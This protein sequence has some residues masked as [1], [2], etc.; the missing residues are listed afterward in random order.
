MT[1][2]GRDSS[3]F[4]HICINCMEEKGEEFVCRYCDYDERTFRLSPSHLRPRMVLQEKYVAGRVLGQGGFG[5]TYIG[6]DTD[7][8]RKVAIKEYFPSQVAH[9]DHNH[10]TIVPSTGKGSASFNKGLEIFIREAR[11]LANFTKTLN[12]VNVY[13]YFS[14]NN[15]AY[16]VMEFLDGHN[17]SKF[18]KSRGGK[19]PLEKSIKILMPVLDTLKAMHAKQFYHRDI[20]PQNIMMTP[21]RGPILIDFGAARQ[22]TGEESQLSDMILKP[23]YSAFESYASKGKIGP[24]TDIY[25]CG[26][27]LYMMITGMPPPPAPDRIHKDDLQ[28]PS[29]IIGDVKEEISKRKLDNVILHALAVK[30]NDRF[31]TVSEFENALKKIVPNGKPH[32]PQRRRVSLALMLVIIVFILVISYGLFPEFRT[33]FSFSNPTP[34]PTSTAAPPTVTPV[35]FSVRDKVRLKEGITWLEGVNPGDIGIVEQID[36]DLLIIR[37]RNGNSEIVSTKDVEKIP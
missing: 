22:I 15:T 17:L 4:L 28:L 10:L 31:K 20:S 3:D 24:W 26:A 21:D 2:Q 27:T 37:L 18:L 7:L 35:T 25:S 33:L 14:K 5:I 11:T 9:R 16:M 1:T 34:V 29:K 30:I 8:T 23:S 36:G 6:F 13:D 19:L 32:L 12:I